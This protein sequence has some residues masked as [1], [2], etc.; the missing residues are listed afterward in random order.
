MTRAPQSREAWYD[1]GVLGR[2]ESCS[3]E[4]SRRI[5]AGAAATAVMLWLAFLLP[6]KALASD[7]EPLNASLLGFTAT[8]LP[9]AVGTTL[10]LTERRETE[11]VRYGAAVTSISVGTVL[12][13]FAGQLYGKAGGDAVLTLLLRGVS[14]A[15]GVGGMT[16]MVRGDAEDQDTGI[17]LS[18]L[19]AIPT[20]FLAGYD[21]FGAA[22]SAREARI[23]DISTE[24]RA[25]YTL[26]LDIA[27][28]GPIPC[29]V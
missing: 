20:L 21:I 27:R 15:V 11:G 22:R 9:V 24:L 7:P 26:L 29:G 18:I 25:E 14:T 28:C 19:G 5:H 17:A 6:A 1:F 12:G 4:S 16:L 10:L 2:L 23:R 13:P 3:W 8:A